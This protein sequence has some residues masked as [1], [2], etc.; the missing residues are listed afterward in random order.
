MV[1]FLVTHGLADIQIRMPFELI[2]FWM[3]AGLPESAITLN[4][5]KEPLDQK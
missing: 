1:L 4:C 2:L 5:Q 3:N